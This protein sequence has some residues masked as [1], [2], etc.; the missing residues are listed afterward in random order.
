MIGIKGNDN[1]LTS[2]YYESFNSSW[3]LSRCIL[4]GLKGISQI[5]YAKDLHAMSHY[6]Q[7]DQLAQEPNADTG[8][9]TQAFGNPAINFE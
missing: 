7:D 9:P 1:R 3:L 2:Y 6:R 8:I 4:V 5:S